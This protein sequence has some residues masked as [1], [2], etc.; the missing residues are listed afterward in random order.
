M[1]K[2]ELQNMDTFIEGMD[3]I[4]VAHKMAAENY[5]SDGSIE[6]ACPPLKALLHIMVHGH[7]KDKTISSTEIRGLFSRKAML[8][9][10]WYKERLKSQQS[11]DV[12]T[13]KKHVEYL[14]AFISKKTHFS[15]KNSICPL[16]VSICP[17]AS[18]PPPPSNGG[19]SCQGGGFD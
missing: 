13:W 1:L 4:E 3:T 12:F 2:P 17:K 16:D 7:Y 6:Q 18:Q 8:A 10:D 14:N 11:Y 9:S 5:F 19:I 15:P